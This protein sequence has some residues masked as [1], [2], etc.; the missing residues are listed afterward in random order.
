M[1]VRTIYLVRDAEKNGSAIKPRVSIERTASG[2]I[3]C[4]V[5]VTAR[6]L[7]QARETAQREF[8]LLMAYAKR[9]MKEETR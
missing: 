6:S 7:A 2:A 4:S 9:H 8:S 3:A 5:H 1:K